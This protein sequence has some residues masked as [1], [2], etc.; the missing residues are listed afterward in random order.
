MDEEG[1]MQV[2]PIAELDV[3]KYYKEFKGESYNYGAIN[4]DVID[5]YNIQ[6]SVEAGEHKTCYAKR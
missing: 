1:I 6:R 5:S 4:K 3:N 2:R